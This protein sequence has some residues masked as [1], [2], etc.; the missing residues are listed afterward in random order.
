MNCDGCGE[1]FPN[2]KSSYCS[3]CGTKRKAMQSSVKSRKKQQEASPAADLRAAISSLKASPK[4]LRL[5]VYFGVPTFV[6]LV[7]GAS[8]VPGVLSPLSE[9]QMPSYKNSF[10]ASEI[11][12]HSV[13]ICSELES[14]LPTQAALG[15]FADRVEKIDEVGTKDEGRRML[16]FKA[17]T[18][19]M[20]GSEEKAKLTMRVD[21]VIERELIELVE[22]YELLGVN[23]S[24]RTTLV[25][26]WKVDFSAQSKS[27]CSFA[28]REGA[29]LKALGQYDSAVQR[30][31][32]LANSAPWYPKGYFEIEAGLAGKWTTGSEYVDCYECNYWTMDVVAKNGCPGGL[33][34]ELSI[35]RSGAAVDWTNDSLSSLGSGQ[36]GKLEFR[37]Y[38]SGS[39][40][41][42]TGT[43]SESN[44]Y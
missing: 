18:D 24:N 14:L 22:G 29:A 39:G 41:S 44:C 37:A 31:I 13:G 20:N 25:D 11:R 4:P 33:Y 23:E 9:E 8:A 1:S 17:K 2:G 26:V 15:E 10:T 32:V 36:K 21:E 5:S 43:I 16:A 3:N 34:V 7:I 42:Y 27:N 40:S 19:W 30:A 6:L 35:L 28:P 38:L 12:E